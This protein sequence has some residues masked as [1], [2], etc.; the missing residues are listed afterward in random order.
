LKKSALAINHSTDQIVEFAYD[1]DAQFLETRKGVLYKYHNTRNADG[2]PAYY[3]W[4]AASYVNSSLDNMVRQ[5]HSIESVFQ[6]MQRSAESRDV[7]YNRVGMF[8]NDA[9]YLTPIDIY[10]LGHGIIDSSNQ[11]AV[12]APFAQ[13]P[14]NDRMIYGPYEAVKIWATRRFELIETR[15]RLAQDP[16]FEMHSERFINST[17]FPAILQ[18]GFH[19]DVN[20][21]I[22]FVRTRADEA[23]FAQDCVIGGK[24]RGFK[25]MGAKSLIENL[26]GKSCTKYNVDEMWNMVGCGEGIRYYDTNVHDTT[27]SENSSD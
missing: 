2:K 15:V 8:R 19:M 12:I 25:G 23:A 16:G 3:P 9:M 21:D 27:S 20:R 26:V 14:I 17:I 18:L 7:T 6:L 1:T 11:Y 24:T 5:W 13:Y 10:K 22:C 4:A